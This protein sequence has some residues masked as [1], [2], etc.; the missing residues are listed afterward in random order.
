MKSKSDA[1]SGDEQRSK[2]SLVYLEVKL[3]QDRYDWCI[4]KLKHNRMVE[5]R[6]SQKNKLL[7]QYR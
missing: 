2:V 4:Y 5:L 1:F 3:H 7:E 6:Y